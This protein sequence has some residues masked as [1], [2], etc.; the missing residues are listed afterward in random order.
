MVS[1]HHM[2]LLL[3]MV[4]AQDIMVD[5]DLEAVDSAVQLV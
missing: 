5:S 1:V 4:L 2:V 3:D